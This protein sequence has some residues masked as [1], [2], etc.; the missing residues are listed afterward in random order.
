MKLHQLLP[1]I[2]KVKAS[3]AKA[4][5]ALYHQVQK[6]DLFDGLSRT[7]TPRDDEGYVYPS[8]AKPIQAQ[9]SDLIA[10]FVEVNRELFDECASQDWTNAGAKADLE[11]DGMV[12]LSDVPVTYLLFL[13]KQVEDLKTFVTALPTQDITEEWSY[14]S[15]RD[16]YASAPKLTTKTKKITK[17]VVLYEATAQHP[18]QVKE[19]SEDVVEGTW[20]AIKFTAA[21]P[22]SEIRQILLRVQKLEK[23][24]IKAREAANQTDAQKKEVAD[25]ILNFV[26][27]RSTPATMS[28]RV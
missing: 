22:P 16:C 25:A 5:T 9:T 18:A 26:F 12:L 8:E 20:T 17:P 11:V 1:I 21:L 2:Q 6:R 13:E 19:S 3:T 7:Y 4:K 10:Q 24:I 28:R 15:A 27:D 23:A 14:D